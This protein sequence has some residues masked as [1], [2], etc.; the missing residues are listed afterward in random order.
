MGA[1]AQ[2]A[3]SDEP[4]YTILDTQAEEPDAPEEVQ[5]EPLLE[6]APHSTA[7]SGARGERDEWRRRSRCDVHLR[8][9]RLC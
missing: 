4:L 6:P 7:L 2:V 8:G 1:P 5:P 9:Q 3:P